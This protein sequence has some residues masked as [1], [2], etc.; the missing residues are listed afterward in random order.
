MKIS[1]T[2]KDPDG[3]YESIREAAKEE[4]KKRIAEGADPEEVTFE[5]VVN[6]IKDALVR[7]LQYSE[8][9]HICIDTEAQ[10]ATVIENRH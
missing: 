5:S 1:M 8:Y 4:F 10:T 7:W 3:V 2:F 9:V 6:E